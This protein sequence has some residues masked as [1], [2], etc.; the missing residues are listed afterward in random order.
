MVTA[1]VQVNVC[2]LCSMCDHTTDFCPLNLNADRLPLTGN[3]SRVVE[4]DKYG[5]TR[6]YQDRKEI[7]NNFNGAKGCMRSNCLFQHICSKCRLT[8]HSQLVCRKRTTQ[9]SPSIKSNTS[10]KV[11][12]NASGQKWLDS[13]ITHAT[14]PVNVSLLQFELRNHPDK[15]FVQYLC[16]GLSYG[17]DTMVKNVN[18]TTKE[19]RNNLSARNQESAVSELIEKR[20]RKWIH[21]RLLLRLALRTF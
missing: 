20:T 18:I 1:G 19:C 8:G 15:S 17:F 9:V 5:R 11:N 6:Q 4:D 2:K 16:E 10:G 12:A 3:K 13:F 7:C 14:T 21:I